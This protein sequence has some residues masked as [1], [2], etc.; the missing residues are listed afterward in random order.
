MVLPYKVGEYVA[1]SF[2]ETQTVTSGFRFLY[3]SLPRHALFSQSLPLFLQSAKMKIRLQKILTAFIPVLL[4]GLPLAAQKPITKKDT[5]TVPA[6]SSRFFSFN[7]SQFDYGNRAY[8]YS[9]I[10]NRLDRFQDY[11]PR[12]ASTGNAGAPEKNLSLPAS[13]EQ[14][15]RRNGANPF[16]YFG[17]AAGMR[18]FYT[19]EKPYTKILYIAGQKQLLDVSVLHAHPFGKNCNIAFAFDRTRST[20]FYRRQNTNNT[21]VNLNGWYRSP[22]RR[23]AMLAEVWWVNNDVAEN[24]GIARDSSFEFATQLDR[25]LVAIN[26]SAAESRQRVRGAWLKQ[27]WSL[28]PVKDTLSIKTDSTDFRTRIQPRWALVHTIS[29][30]DE[31]YRYADGD[32][33]S[34]FYS[35][36]YNDSTET[37]DSTYL[38]RVENGLWIEHFNPRRTEASRILAGRAGIR[39]ESGEIKNDT[40]YSHFDNLYADLQFGFDPHHKW[41]NRIFGNAWYVI[42]GYNKGDYLAKLAWFTSPLTKT[43]RLYLN[44]EASQTHPAFLF[45]HYSGNH[46]RWLNDFS[47]PAFSSLTGGFTTQFLG[48]GLLIGGGWFRY[49]R[50]VYFGSDYLPAQYAGTID[51]FQARFTWDFGNKHLRSS[52]NVTMNLLP[53]NVPVRLP[54]FVVRE[55]FFVDYKLFKSAL[56]IQ[57][58]I[59]ATWFSAY[60]ADGYNPNISQFYV[61][62]SKEIGNYVFLDPWV[63]L[64][65]RPVRIFL[66]AEHVNAGLFGRKYYMIPHYPAND[67]VIK[68]GISWIFN[69]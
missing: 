14:A 50:P 7:E 30:A 6:D 53:E 31:M 34:G 51:A 32:P 43:M 65:V 29:I 27:Y 44:A 41:L 54:Q 15:F 4:C 19:S 55:S 33:A 48:G 37:I 20:G 3:P 35:T 2:T 45:S 8:P 25:Q 5:I 11:K 49:D 46:F 22:G 64:K 17:S 40:I 18:R 38:W 47:S 60:Y 13:A 68:L 58:G 63:S 52:H 62:D 23:Y 24:G 59:D 67:L 39:F 21:N 1:A 42:S 26:L 12:Q 61:Q 57:A 16:A 10:S 66:K 28:G 36:I 56:G 9:P 69:D